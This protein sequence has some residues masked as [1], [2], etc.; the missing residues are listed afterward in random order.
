V[1]RSTI[2]G[3]AALDWGGVG[4]PVDGVALGGLR[5]IEPFID[6]TNGTWKLV[7]LLHRLSK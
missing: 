1:V 4:R 2:R 5:V 3:K 7:A 6:V